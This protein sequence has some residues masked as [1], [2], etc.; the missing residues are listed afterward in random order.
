MRAI[1]RLL[2]VLA[3]HFS[4]L[5]CHNAVVAQPFTF[6]VVNTELTPF[7]YGSASFVDLNNDGFLDFFLTGNAEYDR[8]N[9][10]W[11]PAAQVAIRTFEDLT[12]IPNTLPLQ[13][14]SLPTGLWLG[15]GSWADVDRDGDI[16]LMMTGSATIEPPFVAETILYLNDGTGAFTR[17]DPG[18]VD[19]YGGY[20]RWA[21]Y[22]NDGDSDVLV[23]GLVS[24]DEYVT[25]LYRNE[26]GIFVEDPQNLEVVS[27]GDAA[28][29]DYDSDGDLDLILCGV[30]NG[31]RNLITYANDGRG[32]FS[33]DGSWYGELFCS[34]A[35]GDI[36]SD[37]APDVAVSGG[38]L[39][40][41]Q[42][43]RG[44]TG[45]FHNDGSGYLTRIQ[46]PFVGSYYGD[47]TFADIDQDGDL[48][49]FEMGKAA[50][51]ASHVGKVYANNNG[52]FSI[53]ASLVGTSTSNAAW[54][55]FDNDNDLDVLVSGMSFIQHPFTHLYLN[56]NKRENSPPSSP[57]G[58]SSIVDKDEVSFSW[59]AAADDETASAGLTY[60][61]RVGS[62]P[63]GS[64]ILNPLASAQTGRRWIS[65]RGNVEQNTSWKLR[66]LPNGV[67][68]WAV[69][70]VDNSYIG[71][72]FSEEGAFTVTTNGKTTTGIDETEDLPLH[73]TLYAPFPN[74]FQ[75]EAFLSFD[76]PE[77]MQV[78]I[79]V[80]NLL[81]R[82]VRTILND[83]V[84]AGRHRADWDGR[85]ISGIEMGA[86]V[87]FARF[88]AGSV[89]K[90]IKLV[91][92]K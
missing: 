25:R 13:V 16:D 67:Y 80:Y 54:G 4:L 56:D 86:G 58:L 40:G 51:N 89:V 45:V 64:D 24:P 75:R 27:F 43:M 21:D 62:S 76:L 20:V 31:G 77:T 52:Q 61:L 87:Y 41:L 32:Q 47:V 33:M 14:T 36:D 65:G 11:K 81:G 3:L 85:D 59:N 44:N 5:A 42:I 22:D 68:Y 30:R 78:R 35:L 26:D 84:P 48:D 55:D 50:L 38:R 7:N 29:A 90:S 39:D 69:Q 73:V 79:T 1:I 10:P 53:T 8:F 74:P 66:N 70:A 37:G 83:A 17:T 34:L 91:K 9:N 6:N 46:Q 2:A 60:S 15:N 28:W 92:V 23:S 82:D 18:V 71:S 19:V 72:E 57:T 63:G 88:Q 12:G 49:L